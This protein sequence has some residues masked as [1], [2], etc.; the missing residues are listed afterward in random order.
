MINSKISNKRISKDRVECRYEF[1]GTRNNAFGVGAAPTVL[2]SFF[3]E[4]ASSAG[5]PTN[6]K[7]DRCCIHFGV[8]MF[9]VLQFVI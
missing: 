2:Q 6:L 7:L 1:V 8:R 5:G 9:G 3:L 4:W